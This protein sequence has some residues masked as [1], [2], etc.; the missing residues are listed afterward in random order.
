MAYDA[1]KFNMSYNQQNANS[2]ETHD[3]DDVNY[4]NSYCGGDDDVLFYYISSPQTYFYQTSILSSILYIIYSNFT[5]DS[6]TY[7]LSI[8]IFIY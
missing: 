5:K 7:Y 8:Y 2:H 3:D 4:Y 1:L 6:Y